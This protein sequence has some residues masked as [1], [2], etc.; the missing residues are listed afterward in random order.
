MGCCRGIRTAPGAGGGGT[1]RDGA[2]GR[3]TCMGTVG[4]G[5]A[6]DGRHLQ[7]ENET[8]QK[9]CDEKDKHAPSP[10][11]NVHAP[12][13]LRDSAK[14]TS[15]KDK[16][17]YILMPRREDHQLSDESVAVAAAIG[18][19]VLEDE[20]VSST[21]R[22]ISGIAGAADTGKKKFLL[23]KG[24]EREISHAGVLSQKQS[25]TSP[26][27]NLPG[28]TT[29]KQ[30]HRREASG[31]MIRS[32]LLNKEARQNQSSRVVQSEQQIHTLNLEKDKRPPRPTTRSVLK[33]PISSISQ[34][35]CSSDCDTIRASDEKVVGNDLH[36]F[37][38]SNEKHEKRT[39]NKDRPDRCVWTPRRSD[40]SHAND[41][42]SSSS[43]P[44][45]LLPDSLEG[46]SITQ[47]GFAGVTKIADLVEDSD[48]SDKSFFCSGKPRNLD[49][50]VQN[51]R[52]VRGGNSPSAYDSPV[53]H[54][55]MKVDMPTAGRSG[56]VK[57]LGI[58]RNNSSVENGSHRHV[59]R[60]GPAHIMKD[61]D[62]SLNLSEG[63]PSKRGGATGYGSHEKQ[64]W[65]QKSYSGS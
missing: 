56:E 61:S 60:R 19:E 50:G 40:G 43:Q 38:T 26:V 53:S 17:T 21:D 24:K 15:G 10:R 54:G 64:V 25:V 9:P 2:A 30:N 33:G 20:S 58:G 7:K 44:T 57:T 22:S 55:E 32:I 4:E 47:Y 48:Y 28:S 8:R 37:G 1:Q 12:Y 46:M 63:K 31:G 52:L 42:L 23:L 27:R 3:E 45:Q 62:G 34:A 59:G 13:V 35:A 16:S 29:L 5:N 39:R 41:E 51:T 6:V 36:G 65:V 18:T 14:N 11:S 49:T